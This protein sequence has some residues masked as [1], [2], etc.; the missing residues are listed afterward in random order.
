VV[1]D[2][3]SENF[4]DRVQEVTGGAGAD[5]VYDPVGGDVLFQSLRCIAWGGRFLVIGFAG[6]TIPEVPANYALLKS[7]SVIGVRA[8]EYGRRDPA[9]GRAII[10]HMLD[11]AGAGRINPHV[12]ARLPLVDAARA[13]ALL[14]RREVIGKVVLTV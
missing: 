13:L 8:G 7:C 6:G 5:V 4:R 9:A 14:S 2:H 3:R 11:L 1:V 12:H 10:A